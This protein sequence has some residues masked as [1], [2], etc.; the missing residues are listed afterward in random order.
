M[1][2]R[3]RDEGLDDVS[4]RAHQIDRVRR[5]APLDPG[6]PVAYRVDGASL[7]GAHRLAAGEGG[8]GGWR[9][10][11]SISGSLASSASLRP[12]QSP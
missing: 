6:V 2:E 10:T 5:R 8:R 9:W 1:P 3:V 11:T 7:H 12:D 4:V